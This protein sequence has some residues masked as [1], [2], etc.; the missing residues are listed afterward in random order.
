MIPSAAT[1]RAV[2]EPWILTTDPV[3]HAVADAAMRVTA[4][5][6]AWVVAVNGDSLQVMAAVGAGTEQLA[7]AVVPEETGA[8]GYVIASG[9]PS[10]L[11]GGD[12]ADQRLGQGVCSLLARPP[13][14]LLSVPCVADGV[15]VG[16]VE[17][18]DKADGAS[19]SF[20]DVELA[21]VVASI[22]AAALGSGVLARQYVLSPEALGG[23]LRRLASVD[24]DRY[25]AISGVLTALLANG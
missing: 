3:L 16:G 23:E 22:A 5:S 13:A 21:S 14:S 11:R 25:T 18:A 4:G 1:I 20:T 12:G 19:F 2:S 10:A 9:Q 15:V 8:I 17:I 7:T 6:A 24:R